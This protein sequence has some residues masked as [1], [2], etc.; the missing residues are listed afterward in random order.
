[1]NTRF[2][3][4]NLLGKDEYNK[5]NSYIKS[6]KKTEHIEM[7]CCEY[8][9]FIKSLINKNISIYKEN[10][11]KQLH[12]YLKEINN[13]TSQDLNETNFNILKKAEIAR[14]IGFLNKYYVVIS[15]YELREKHLKP[16]QTN[17]NQEM[18]LS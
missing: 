1:M 17:Q 13:M 11:K 18:S 3:I 5:F 2:K 6:N 16:K 8:E 9:S 12:C 7:S 15:F 10:L 4:D 14:Q